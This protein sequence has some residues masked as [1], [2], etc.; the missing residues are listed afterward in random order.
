[1]PYMHILGPKDN[2]KY[3]RHVKKLILSNL[4]NQWITNELNQPSD[5]TSQWPD[6]QSDRATKNIEKRKVLLHGRQEMVPKISM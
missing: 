6:L 1:M 5:H 4:P 3:S 2:K